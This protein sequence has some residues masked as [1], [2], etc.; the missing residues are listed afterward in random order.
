M[1]C[2]PNARLEEL[3]GNS[4]YCQSVKQTA[5]C[6]TPGDTGDESSNGLAWPLTAA[7]RL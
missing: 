4:R 7:F 3:L 1:R 5:G 6:V 2:R